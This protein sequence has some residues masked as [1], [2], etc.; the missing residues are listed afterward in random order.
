MLPRFLKF[1]PPIFSLF[2]LSACAALGG[3][4]P[5]GSSSSTPTTAAA[6]A[7]GAATA[8]V[9]SVLD[10]VEPSTKLAMFSPSALLDG[11][12]SIDQTIVQSQCEFRTADPPFLVPTSVANKTWTFTGR[13]EKAKATPGAQDAQALEYRSWFGFGT[14]KQQL[15]SWPVSMVTLSEM[16]KAYLDDRLTMLSDH[17]YQVNKA[18]T[19]ALA[20]DYI[21][22]SRKIQDRVQI[23]VSS[24]DSSKC[25][26]K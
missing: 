14:G 8:S 11:S 23:L 9:P 25:P 1:L 26:T 7:A 22:D 13:I 17:T 18:Q 3:L 12:T 21:N 15:N 5:G 24:F 6:P 2:A 19:D 16:P 4:L 20:A 10:E